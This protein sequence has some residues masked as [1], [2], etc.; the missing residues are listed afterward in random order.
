MGKRGYHGI[1]EKNYLMITSKNSDEYANPL[2]FGVRYDGKEFVMHK[3][4]D[5]MGT[6]ALTGR[7]FVGTKFYIHMSG[8]KFD[9]YAFKRLFSEGKFTDYGP[10]KMSF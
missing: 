4:L 8:H 2:E 10:E 6:L 3:I 7:H 1:T 9:L 5:F